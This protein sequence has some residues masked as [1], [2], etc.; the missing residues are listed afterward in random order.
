MEAALIG[1]LGGLLGIALGFT[2]TPWFVGV[3]GGQTAGAPLLGPDIAILTVVFAVF[4]TFLSVFRSARR[5]SNMA[6]VD[7]LKE[8][9]YMEEAKPYRQTWPWA[10][11][12]LGSFKMAVFFLGVNLQEGMTQ[13]RGASPNI[14]VFFLSETV[15]VIDYGL[16]YLGPFLFFWGFTKILIGGSVKFQEITTRAVK[17]LG[18][19]GILATKNV[20]RKPA[21][22]AA[23]AFLV[24]FIIGY[25]FQAV[26]T[27]ASQ[28][29][30]IL[31][32]AKLAVGSDVSLTLNS[33]ANASQVMSIIRS[34]V[35]QIQSVSAEYSLTGT[36]S[37]YQYPSPM[38]FRAVTPKTWLSAAYY[39]DDMFSGNSAEKTFETMSSNNHTIILDRTVAEALDKK[40]G[41]VVTVTFSGSTLGAEETEQLTVVGLFGLE[42][43]PPGQY[44]SYIPEGLY[45]ELQGNILSSASAK[46]LIKLQ[47]GVDSRAVAAQLRGSNISGVASVSSLV[48]QTEAQQNSSTV[49]GSLSIVGLGVFF[50]VVAASIGTALIMLVSLTE[51]KREASIMSVR[52]LSFK[53][54]LVMFLTESL[55]VVTF[56]AFLGTVGGL[57][58]LRGVVA[59]NN[60]LNVSLSTVSYSSSSL[61]IPLDMHMVFQPTAILTL[62]VSFV[63]VFAS[64]IIPT[65]LMTR[66]YSTKLERVVR[67]V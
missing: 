59:S 26:G 9:V 31:R 41:D 53:Q 10:A 17:F 21:R 50:M 14:L 57:I 4:V 37:G 6:A 20:R 44:W 54:L 2:L 24:A 29:D 3:A 56:A 18:D 15:A 45:A 7:A 30:L 36:L 12:I 27:L 40:V 39:E 46:I 1:L 58:V 66:R 42:S 64:T 33:P 28:R 25:S 51:R 48:E 52:G 34:N 65:V 62:F 67:E 11:L 19:L 35:S 16:N 13:L 60:A 23:V 63:L 43:A 49:S 32:E 22:A 38:Q 47:S 8:Y 61:G 55:S 5:A